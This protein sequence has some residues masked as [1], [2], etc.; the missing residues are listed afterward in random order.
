MAVDGQ[1]M[2]PK[3]VTID[4]VDMA[5]E[6]VKRKK[7]PV[8]LPKVKFEIIKEGPAAQI[9][10]VGPFSAE[11][12]TIAKIHSRILSTGHALNG[13]PHEIYLNNPATTTPEKLKT[14][15]R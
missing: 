9:M 5:L 13:K 11:G 10:Y 2:Q 3:Y 8:A 4:Y 7:N 12:P 1:I 6:Q 14:I 15:I